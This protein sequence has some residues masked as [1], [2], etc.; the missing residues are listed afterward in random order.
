MPDD[1]IY[2]ATA[3]P[4]NAA[5]LAFE[6]RGIGTDDRPDCRVREAHT[7][8]EGDATHTGIGCPAC[9]AQR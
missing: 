3:W 1:I 6:L 2:A 7:P 4:T 5:L 8:R 9:D